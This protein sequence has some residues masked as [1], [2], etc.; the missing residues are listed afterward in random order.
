MAKKKRKGNTKYGDYSNHDKSK[1]ESSIYLTGSI[2]LTIYALYSLG[3]GKIVLPTRHDSITLYGPAM[4]LTVF[5]F[6]TI[7]INY[8]LPYISCVIRE[9][10]PKQSNEISKTIFITR[11]WLKILSWILWVTS[12]FALMFWN[13]PRIQPL[14][15]FYLQQ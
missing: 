14:N 4:A 6:L 3:M 8:S 9:S 15:E 5:T 11:R 13:E 1:M 10:N 7:S 2:L 12:I